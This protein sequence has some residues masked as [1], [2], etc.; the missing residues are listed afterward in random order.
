M[1]TAELIGYDLDQLVAKCEQAAGRNI[2]VGFNGELLVIDEHDFGAPAR[3]ST[4]QAQGGQI[5]DRELIGTG[6]AWDR[7]V[8]LAS[9]H[10]PD[11]LVYEGPTRLIA[12]MRCYVSSKLGDEVEV[13]EELR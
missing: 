10:K 8:W 13:P 4:D 12:A 2:T 9:T 1:K 11:S 5:I 6:H 3:Y 7:P